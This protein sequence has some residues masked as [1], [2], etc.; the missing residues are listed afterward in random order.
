[1][2]AHI[3]TS[4][5]V[6]FVGDSTFFDLNASL[7]YE[8]ANFYGYKFFS[9]I[10]FNPPIYESNRGFRD[11]KIWFEIPELGVNF[12]H[13]RLN[14]GFD[15]GRFAFQ[16]DWVDNYVQGLSFF[17][18]YSPLIDYSIT[19]INQSA[20]IKN[21]QMKEFR[22]AGN[23]LGGLLLE[24]DFKIP[25]TIITINSYI[26]S[27]ADLFW[28][29]SVGAN[30]IFKILRLNA[31][32]IWKGK[33]LTYVAYHN[34]SYGGSGVLFWSDLIYKDYLRNFHVGGGIMA[35]NGVKQL[36]VFG[37]NTEFENIDGMLDRGATTLY[38]F[39]KA[40][41]LPAVS[42]KAGMRLSIRE[43]EN[44]F[45]LEAKVGYSPIPKM[46]LAIGFLMIN[47][48]ENPL[49]DRYILKTFLE[50]HF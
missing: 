6:D 37:Q 11:N 4:S 35:T 46:E 36:S 10:W 8:S 16:A 31:D 1:M 47:G 32:V 48:F 22:S 40:V 7:A 26:Y 45:G 44:L 30:A 33:L 49:N 38:V 13:S 21:Y 17:H 42:L 18:T 12:F 39:G 15:A 27:V 20:L 23:W 5:H 3:G 24:A 34:L 25:A 50:Y 29:P 28:A 43:Q 14:Y 9:S 2:K 19:W 41:P